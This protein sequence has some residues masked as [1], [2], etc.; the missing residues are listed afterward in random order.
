MKRTLLDSFY[1]YLIRIVKHSDYDIV[2]FGLKY[3]RR[4]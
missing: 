4:D 1:Q 2:T 3:L